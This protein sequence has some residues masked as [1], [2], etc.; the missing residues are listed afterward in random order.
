[1]DN[2][3][4]IQEQIFEDLPRTSQVLRT[5]GLNLGKNTLVGAF[6]LQKRKRRCAQSHYVGKVWECRTKIVIKNKGK[7]R[8]KD[9]MNPGYH[10]SPRKMEIT[11]PNLGRHCRASHCH[12]CLF[13]VRDTRD[14]L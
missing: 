12:K 5:S 6:L 1:M 13:F 3:S 9:G 11:E 4:S 8:G 2:S 14:V 7:N 10:V